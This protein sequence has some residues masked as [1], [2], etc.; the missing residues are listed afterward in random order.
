MLS[1]AFRSCPCIFE[2]H[3]ISEGIQGAQG[4]QILDAS[5]KSDV[6]QT[7]WIVDVLCWGLLV[8]MLTSDP[9]QQLVAFWKSQFYNFTSYN[10]V[11][12]C[13]RICLFSAVLAWASQLCSGVCVVLATAS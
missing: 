13:R 9:D 8:P 7:V 10:M 12:T 6:L 3:S 5:L 1:D 4:F 11:R 2:T